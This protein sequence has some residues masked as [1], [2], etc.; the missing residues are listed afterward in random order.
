MLAAKH[1]DG[2][3][4]PAEPSEAPRIVSLV[5]SA[6]EILAA[7]GLSQYVV[8]RSHECDYPPELYHVPACTAPLLK[9]GDISSKINDTISSLVTSGLSIYDLDLERLR[10]LDPSHI[11]T[12]DRC[13]VCAVPLQAVEVALCD[14][15]LAQTQ[16]VSLKPKRL[17]DIWSDIR[18]IGR[19]FG[20][21][22]DSLA[23]SLTSRVERISQQFGSREQHTPKSVSCLEWAD[24]IYCAGGWLPDLISA[25]GGIEVTGKAGCDAVAIECSTLGDADPSVIIFA[26]C[27]FNLKRAYKDLKLLNS[28]SDWQELRAVKTG[29]LYVVDGNQ[30]FSRPGPR[31]VES[32]EIAA[33]ILHPK[34]FNFGHY[35]KNWLRVPQPAVSRD[36]TTTN[37]MAV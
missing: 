31:L 34:I 7:L 32:V 20:V 18:R 19:I 12:Q 14:L 15:G 36:T 3:M 24:P 16:V 29:E 35:G 33:E 1:A 28:R 2:P 6:T 22:G 13:D 11:V 21:E 8:G 10:A 17:N 5:P 9:T 26:P 23:S 30:F 25:A 27:G 4:V 37:P